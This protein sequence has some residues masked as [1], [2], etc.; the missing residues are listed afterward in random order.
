MGIAYKG[1]NQ[2]Y[3]LEISIPIAL[4]FLLFQNLHF[5]PT[6]LAPAPI[7]RHV[8]KKLMAIWHSTKVTHIHNYICICILT[9]ERFSELLLSDLV[10]LLL[11]TPC[12]DTAR[13]SLTWLDKLFLLVHFAYKRQNAI[14]SE[15]G[16]EMAQLLN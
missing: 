2:E 6:K 10:L 16:H 11:G 8:T 7:I 12:P 13:E 4:F 3:L 9:F 1:F 15:E 5:P 14:F